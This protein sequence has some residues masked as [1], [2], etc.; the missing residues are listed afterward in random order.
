M[1]R[2][3]ELSYFSTERITSSAQGVGP[4]QAQT[5]SRW[6]AG[7]LFGEVVCLNPPLGI[8]TESSNQGSGETNPSGW[9][10]AA[11]IPGMASQ[12]S[13]Q[14]SPGSPKGT[15]LADHLNGI[16]AACRREAT[17]RTNQG[18]DANLIEANQLDQD[19]REKASNHA[20]GGGDCLL[21]VRLQVF[22]RFQSDR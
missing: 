4:T 13:F 21:Q 9:I 12:D 5:L 8:R 15:V 22:G 2:S 18:T 14:R 6:C 1:E 7:H 16:L 20:L 3:F 10:V 19:G 11:R 17:G